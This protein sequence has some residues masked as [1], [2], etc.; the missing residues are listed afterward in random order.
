[1][2]GVF[3]SLIVATVMV[4]SLASAQAET[5]VKCDTEDSF[6][7]GWKSPVT[8]TYSGGDSGEIAIKSEHVT[9]TVPAHMT[10]DQTELQGTKVDRITMMGTAQT[11]SNMPEP[12]AL[13]AC[14]LAELKPEEL[15]DSDAQAVAFMKCAGKVPLAQVPVTAHAMIMLLPIS[16]PSKLE[17]MVQTTRTYEG[18]KFPWGADIKLETMPGGDCTLS[19]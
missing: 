6:I 5:I 12:V 1:M 3:K 15:K 8:L 16:D 14:I 7:E 13:N 4:N 9:F 17:P 19:E 18:A 10:K 2:T 11:T